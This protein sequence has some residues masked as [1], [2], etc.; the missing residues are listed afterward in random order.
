[1]LACSPEIHAYLWKLSVKRLHSTSFPMSNMVYQ[2]TVW[3]PPFW[4]TFIADAS[5]VLNN[6][7]F[8]D[9]VYADDLNGFNGYANHISDEVI[10][11]DLG[12]VQRELHNWGFANQVS[13]D[14]SKESAHILSRSR[15]VGNDF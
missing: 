2:G 14:A 9:S 3:G 1:M 8:H 15:P 4:N 5:V 10:L 11:A 6:A 7:G 12:E 13:F